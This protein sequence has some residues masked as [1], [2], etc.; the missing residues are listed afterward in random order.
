MSGHSVDELLR[1]A[2]SREFRP[3]PL[4]LTIR[5]DLKAK[6][7][8]I[9]SRN[10]LGMVQGSDAQAAQRVRAVQRPLGSSWYCASRQRRCDLQRR[11]R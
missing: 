5:A 10:V 6:I 1:A 2:D 8:K 11:D 7:R 3:I 4:N 9:E